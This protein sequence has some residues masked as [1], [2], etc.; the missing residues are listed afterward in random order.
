MTDPDLHLRPAQA[1]DGPRLWAWRN[2]PAVRA[3]SL[4]TDPIPLEAHLDWFARALA[5]PGRTLLIAEARGIPI[6]MVRLDRDDDT[7]TVSILLAP[8]A[9]GQGLAKPVL[10]AAL[11][12][13]TRE[14]GRLRAVVR[15]GTAASLALF[16]GLGFR[17]VES[18][19]TVVLERPGGGMGSDGK[20]GR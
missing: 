4:S 15:A 12:G 14:T 9:R 6:G 18:G 19:E 13:W 5:D 11:Q 16:T 7:A 20:E 2:D 3:A 8:Q 17:P 10:S 1:D